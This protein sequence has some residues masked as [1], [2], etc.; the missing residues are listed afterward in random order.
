VAIKVLHPELA[1]RPTILGR[2][3]DEARI[4][5]LVRHHCVVQVDALAEVD[6]RTAI[7]MEYVEGWDLA[8]ILAE[9]GALPEQ[10]ALEVISELAGALHVAWHAQGPNGPLKL[11]HRDIKPANVRLTPHGEVKLLDFGLARAEIGG[12][13]GDTQ[14]R[15][16][17][18]PP[19]MA[20]ERTCGL[21]H[22]GADVYALGLCLVALVG[23]E[24]PDLVASDRKTHGAVL[25]WAQERCPVGLQALVAEM[26]S[27]GPDERPL[28]GVVQER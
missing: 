23:G 16:L 25:A 21:N 4:L 24:G 12:R 26:L 13:E 20:P 2:L 7:I 15:V 14:F 5:A 3:R 11:Q 9:R 1:E 17:G 27:Y 18:T 19:Y 28:A 8:H 10:A 6:G 22:P